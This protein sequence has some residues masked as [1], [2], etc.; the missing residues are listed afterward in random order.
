MKINSTITLNNGVEMPQYGL[1]VWR[2]KAGQETENAV[3]WALEA[4]YVH[5][6]TAAL[7][8]NEF[9]VG[10]IVREGIVPRENVFVTS[11]LWVDKMSYAGAQSAFEH[12]MQN[13]GFDYLDLYLLHWPTGDWKGAWRALEE[14]YQQGRVRAIGV[15][16]F[17]QH[18]LEELLQI[19][20]IAPAVNQYEMHPYLQQAELRQFC[21]QNG[22]AVTAW[23]PIMKGQVL[24][25][26]TLVEIGEKYGKSAV[27]VSLRWLLQ[28]GVI[29]IPKSVNQNRIIDNAKIFDFELTDSEMAAINALDRD[30]RVGP[31]PDHFMG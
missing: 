31:H 24:D 20:D 18:H 17:L 9:E 27:H 16:N 11:K 8:Q 6:D 14:F 12:T 1:G 3:R 30:Q 19:G 2:S 26:P 7:Y 4:G 29:V 10:K 13:L 22:I 28:L 5:I 25:I 15:S 23:A 21:Q